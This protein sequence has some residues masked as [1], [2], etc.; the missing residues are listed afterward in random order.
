MSG[1]EEEANPA[2]ARVGEDWL[3]VIVAGLLVAMALLWGSSLAGFELPRYSWA[4]GGE[5]GERVLSG[6]NLGRVL[7][8]GLVLYPVAVVGLWAL[9]ES[10]KSALLGFPVLYVVAVAALI[11]AG[12]ATFH[13]YGLEYVIWA[14]G[15]GLLLG[16]TVRIPGWLAVAARS[17]FYIKI[18]LVLLGSTVLWREIVRAGVPGI[19]QSLVV[20]F[21]VWSFS[22]WFARKLGVDEEFAAI[23]STA[24]SICGVS[25]AIAA[26]GA[27]QGDRK[28]LSYTTTIVVLCAVPMLIVMPWIVTA[29]GIDEIVAGAWLGGTLDTTASVAAAAELVGPAA[30]KV[31]T[32][33]KFSQNLLLGLAAFFLAIWW[34]LRKRV[35]VERPSVRII[36]ERFPKFVLGFVAA[37]LLFSFLVSPETTKQ[38]SPVLGALRTAWFALAFVSI[39]LE[40]RVSDL[41]QLEGGRP[42]LAFVGAQAF[43][44][45]FTLIIAYLMFGGLLLPVPELK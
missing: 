9:G 12:N 37:S 31:G 34:T 11:L 35:D 14:L 1:A 29:F 10:I 21:V 28:K 39:G 38:V 13:Q 20:V 27:V 33:V 23:L 41:V 2:R 3:A 42:A 30:T 5:L 25:A 45:V 19:L 16:N 4:T 36:W 18:G 22:F 7:Q 44:V 40:A 32:I 15:F 17:E 43:N 6:A 24:V 8:V 26:S